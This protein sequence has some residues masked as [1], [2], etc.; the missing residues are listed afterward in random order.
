MPVDYV[1]LEDHPDLPEF[2]N[3]V[4]M[5]FGFCGLLVIQK[6]NK[7]NNAA[8]QLRKKGYYDMWNQEALDEVVTWRTKP[9]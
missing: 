2:V 8:D 4:Q 5:N 3:G 7:L 9:E 1:I 6:L